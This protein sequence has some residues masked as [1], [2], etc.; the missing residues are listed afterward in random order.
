MMRSRDKRQPKPGN[1]KRGNLQRRR[2]L[3][4]Y[5][6]WH[7]LR[8]MRCDAMRC[9]AMRCDAM[10]RREEDKRKDEKGRVSEVLR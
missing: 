1:R 4:L 9:D 3:A 2:G 10:Q 5:A 7:C 8:A 6:E